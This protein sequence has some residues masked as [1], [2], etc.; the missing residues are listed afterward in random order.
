M[1]KTLRL[2]VSAVIL[3]T[4]CQAVAGWPAAAQGTS[5]RLAPYDGGDP[6]QVES[7]SKTFPVSGVPRVRV[8]TFDGHIRIYGWDR[9]AV[10]FVAVKRAKDE[11]ERRG[12]S[13]RAEQR[14]A[15]VT[16]AAAFDRAFRREVVMNGHRVMSDS[17]QV[18]LEIY[19]PRNAHLRAASG[20]NGISMEGVSGEMDLRTKDGQIRVSGGHGRLSVETGDGQIDIADFDG[21]ADALTDDGQINLS[22]RFTRLNARTGDGS[23]DL[24]LLADANAVIETSAER[25]SSPDG[26]AV[27]EDAVGGS[28]RL[29]RWRV[30]N[31]GAVFTLHANH[32]SI[33]SSQSAPHP[34][35]RARR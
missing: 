24:Q 33:R 12:I 22:G 20:D 13:L 31:G 35:R 21:E 28:G 34:R 15:E 26:L 17:A 3:S 11:H 32:V 4:L 5:A 9:P 27:A 23:I 1:R 2:A 6:R 25:V 30:G 19:V 10:M 16:I 18:D 14:G 29:R 7:E 8:E